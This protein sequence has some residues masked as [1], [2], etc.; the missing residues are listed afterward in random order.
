MKKSNNKTMLM[1]SFLGLMMAASTSLVA[2]NLSSE[3]KLGKKLYFDT[4]LSEPNGQSCASCHTPSAGFAE[5]DSNLAVSEGVISGLFGGRNAPTASYAMFVPKFGFNESE[6][7]W[8]GGLFWDGRATGEKL[9]DPLAHQALGPFLNPVEMANPS[10]L[11]VVR[12]AKHS[13]Y[14]N[15][16][17]NVCGNTNLSDEKDVD[18]AYNCIAEAI[19][20]FERTSRFAQ[21][22]SK[23][24]RYLQ[25]CV[26]FT[27]KSDKALDN[28]AQGVGIEAK[29]ASY[30]TY[31]REE[32]KGLQ[33]F[34]GP[35]NN[36]GKMQWGEGANCA[37]CHSATWTNDSEYVN[38]IS[39]PYWAPK[40]KV[41]PLFTDH[42]YDNL[43]IPA[44]TD[45]VMVNNGIDL[46]L[47]ALKDGENG[48]FRVVGLRNIGATAPYAHNGI[49]INLKDIVHFYN[50][51]D[52]DSSI[53]QP[54]VSENMNRDEL[55][56]LGLSDR[57]ERQLVK[58][59]NTLTD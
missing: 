39:K 1:V 42:T 19:G 49:F 47:G 51:R 20:N 58:F 50:S 2:G 41:P 5:P 53:A 23:Y 8:T 59:L 15:L 32:W 43:G 22:T 46:G 6:G 48:K 24:D 30:F 40:G 45:P 28:C 31:T 14:A 54:E 18:D 35:N 29:F 52:V 37:S 16:Y 12:D 11:T 55:G 21:F 7:L 17:E 56:N 3:E 44:N 4:N 27:N 10:K 34:M 38:N 25:K 26:S 13:I 57:Q 36:D 33:L 9:N